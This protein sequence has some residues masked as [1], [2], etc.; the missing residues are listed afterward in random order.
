VLLEVRIE[1][2]GSMESAFREEFGDAI[3]LGL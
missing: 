1:E 2:V 3:C